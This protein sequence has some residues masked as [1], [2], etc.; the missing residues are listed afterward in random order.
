MPV[1]RRL[2]PLFAVLAVLALAGCGQE[3]DERKFI[4]ESRAER[5]GSALDRV[6]RDLQEG[7]CD[8]AASGVARVREEVADLPDRTD[9]RLVSNLGEWVDHL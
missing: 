3:T 2:R 6:Q 9:A 5:L 4:A 7:D 8:R 1:P